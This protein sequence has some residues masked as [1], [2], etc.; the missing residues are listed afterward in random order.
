M[1][2]PKWVKIMAFVLFSVMV[3]ACQTNQGST[4]TPKMSAS[5]NYTQGSSASPIPTDTID[6]TPTIA[7]PTPAP[8]PEPTLSPAEKKRIQDLKTLVSKYKKKPMTDKDFEVTYRGFT[9]T[10]KSSIQDIARHLG[11]PEDFED[12]NYGYVSTKKDIRHWGLIYPLSGEEDITYLISSENI[13]GQEVLLA[14][15]S[16]SFVRLEKISTYR[17]VKVGDSIKKVLDLYGVPDESVDESPYRFTYSQGN[18]GVEISFDT[19]LDKVIYI[20]INYQTDSG[21][22]FT[23]GKFTYTVKNKQACIVSYEGYTDNL[24]IPSTLDGLP[25]TGID[26]NDFLLSSL[27]IPSGVTDISQDT[28]SSC[29]VS[30]F[31]V[32]PNN[33]AYSSQDGVLYNK[34]KTKLLR[35]PSDKTGSFNIP[36]SV[37]SIGNSA[38]HLCNSL[39][40][41]TIPNSVTVIEGS[42]FSDCS[43][44]TSMTI[45]SSV[46]V[47]EDSAFSNCSAL[48]SITIPKSVISLNASAFN[49]CQA[50]ASIKVDANNSAFCS[51]DGILYNKNK[52]RLIKCPAGKQGNITIPNIVTEIGDEAFYRCES[53]LS[54]TIPNSVKVIGN[55]AF[56]GCNSLISLAIGSNVTRIGDMAF[57]YCA[58]LENIK[59]GSG[60]NSIGQSA[61][62]YCEALN[63]IDVDVKN[64]VYSSLDGVL[65]NKAKTTIVQVPRKKSGT[66]KIIDGVTSI[67]EEAFYYCD[68]LTSVIIPNSVIT[69]GN[70]AFEYCT[71]LQRM[72]IPSHVTSIGDGAFLHCG[73][74]SSVKVT[75][76]TKS[77]G[78]CAFYNCGDDF[79]L[80][81]PKGSYAQTYAKLFFIEFKA[82]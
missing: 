71:S 72:T 30:R 7:T 42:A 22:E 36:G 15:G 47:M 24:T 28:I 14:K 33:H 19:N 17:G 2:K 16:I 20:N 23:S 62:V 55:D 70:R 50:I 45:P 66:F 43:A 27:T 53:I 18:L 12:N 79:V 51:Q 4:S 69:I 57:L 68:L 26:Y 1:P 60:V 76:G 10:P 25:V 9:V 21:D 3:S 63:S 48:T 39:I 46:T 49:D 44:L 78:L 81:V 74:L 6:Q 61:F 65:Y 29:F 8:T 58:S 37:K 41:I 77:I 73:A 13:S 64:K 31:I 75:A 54:I 40:S 34:N 32:D 5:P 59:I 56:S 52:T 82:I 38:F 11:I 35:C 80:S 67:G